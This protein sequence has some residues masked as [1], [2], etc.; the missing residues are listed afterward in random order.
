MLSALLYDNSVQR[1]LS[2]K[3]ENL[4]IPELNG[5][6]GTQNIWEFSIKVLAKGI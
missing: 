3:T 6:S 5:L 1:N 4:K 2:S